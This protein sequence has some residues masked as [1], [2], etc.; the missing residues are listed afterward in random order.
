VNWKPDMIWFDNHQ[1]YGSANYY[2]QKLFM[3]HQGDQLIKTQLSGVQKNQ[4]QAIQEQIT[5]PITGKLSV[6]GNKVE[7]KFYE[8]KLINNDTGEEKNY[9]DIF[10]NLK[11]SL[12][13]LSKTDWVNY[14]L[15]LKV[16]KVSGEKG[17][18][19]YF[20]EKDEDNRLLWE[21]GGW[22]NQDS[23]VSANIN[24]RSSCLTQSQ[25]NVEMDREYKLDLQVCE[26][27]IRT[28]I[29]GELIN[30]TIDMLPVIEELYYSASIES[31]TGNIIIKVV[32][33]QEIAVK[34]Q[35][36]L[37]GIEV[38]TLNGTIF[39][40]AG[41]KPED[42]N[43]FETPQLVV[44]KQRDINFNVKDFFYEFPKQSITIFRLLS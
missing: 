39:E 43:S 10:T 38:E 12:V 32:N 15:S 27:H 17:F 34:S 7:A 21:I 23:M 11:S 18:I 30:D 13:E 4:G 29:D 25:F 19:V 14:T 42:E 36:I 31:S 20:G 24:R 2:V 9:A 3:N 37:D 5:P 6:A 35:L 33:V 41:Y 8:I 26:R 40:M 44:P 16:K 1:V 28:F 22:Q